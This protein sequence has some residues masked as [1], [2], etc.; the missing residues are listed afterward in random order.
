L[1]IRYGVRH[2]SR[3]N[4]ETRRRS[5]PGNLRQAQEKNPRKGKVHLVQ[6]DPKAAEIAKIPVF[7]LMIREFDAREQ[8]A[9]AC[10]TRHRRLTTATN[11]S[12]T[13]KSGKTSNDR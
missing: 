1:S 7:S 4:A 5:Q 9:S 8:F 13:N 6:S 10:V 12:A 11:K 3:R 2:D